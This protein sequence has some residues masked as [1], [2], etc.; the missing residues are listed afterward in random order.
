[1]AI[2]V[3]QVYKTVLLIINKEQRGYLTPDEFNKIGTQVQLDIFESYFETLNQQLRLPQNESDYANRVKTVNEK[4]DVFKKIQTCTF[5][6]AT[7]TE[8][9]YFSIPSA[10]AAIG[11]STI[12][13]FEPAGSVL[14]YPLTTIKQSQVNADYSNVTVTRDGVTFPQSGNWTITGG[15]FV[16]VAEQNGTAIVITL[17]PSLYKLGTVIYN[18]EQEL[19]PVQR[20]EL[21]RLNLSTYTKP[22]TDYPVYLY[23]NDKIIT[24]PQTIITGIQASYVGKPSNPVWNFTSSASGYVYN[25]PISID[26]ELQIS[27]QTNVILQILLYA[28]VVIKD[29]SIVQAATA[30]IAQTEQNER[31]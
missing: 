19:Q 6:A 27:E 5:T 12:Q 16:L 8:L 4:I 31:T 21:V 11:Q 20:S 10:T 29:P 28:G 30:E 17:S 9:A 23:E 1:M 15:N 26:F 22:S 2:N 18:E 14:T 24:Y 7:A 3:D 13:T 25:A